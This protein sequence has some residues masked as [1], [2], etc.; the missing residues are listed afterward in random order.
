MN[1]LFPLVD[2]FFSEGEDKNAGKIFPTTCTKLLYELEKKGEGG[3]FDLSEL[4]KLYSSSAPTGPLNGGIK[5]I[6]ELDEVKNLSFM[7]FIREIDGE[8]YCAEAYFSLNAKNTDPKNRILDQKSYEFASKFVELTPYGKEMAGGLFEFENDVKNGIR[9]EE[10]AMKSI[11]N[12]IQIFYD[13]EHKSIL[14]DEIIRLV[15]LNKKMNIKE[16]RLAAFEFGLQMYS[17]DIFEVAEMLCEEGIFTRAEKFKCA[18]TDEGKSLLQHDGFGGDLQEKFKSLAE[19][20]KDADGFLNVP[21]KIGGFSLQKD[22]KFE[23]E[24]AELLSNLMHKGYV[25][26]SRTPYECKSGTAEKMSYLEKSLSSYKS[27]HP[28]EKMTY[29]KML[30]KFMNAG[31]YT[32]DI[33]FEKLMEH[34]RR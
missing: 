20:Y 23:D 26:L 31:L 11:G 5:M 18:V 10:A 6:H 8:K 17:L 16:I 19:K 15:R 22:Y 33:D 21:V 2:F 4:W 12:G 32:P 24:N 9:T 34:W 30:L 28:D 29:A 7:R 13:K 14:R 25:T 1:S 27:S 3:V